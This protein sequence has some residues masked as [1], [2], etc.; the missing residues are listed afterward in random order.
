[1]QKHSFIAFVFVSLLLGSLVL[2]TVGSAAT[3]AGTVG[4]NPQPVPPFKTILD[5]MNKRVGPE[6]NAPAFVK[7]LWTALLKVTGFEPTSKILR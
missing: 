6:S 4:L 2:T 1:M 5:W 7:L 3:S